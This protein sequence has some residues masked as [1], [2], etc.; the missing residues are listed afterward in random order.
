[1]KF[2]ALN[3]LEKSIG[4]YVEH[5]R[6]IRENE[7]N[8]RRGIYKYK[9]N[10][11]NY[12]LI[13]DNMWIILVFSMVVYAARDIQSRICIMSNLYYYDNQERF[14]SLLYGL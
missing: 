13:V 2:V 8:K 11:Q 14:S 3:L 4:I 5:Y 12:P 10:N 7:T 6:S 1:M 9:Q